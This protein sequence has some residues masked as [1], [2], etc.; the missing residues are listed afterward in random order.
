MMMIICVK[1]A[2]T[3]FL[4]GKNKNNKIQN[5]KYKYK[6]QNTNTNTNTTKK[7]KNNVHLRIL[8]FT[9]H[10]AD[11]DHAMYCHIHSYQV[12]ASDFD[13]FHNI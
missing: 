12:L 8:F 3:C 1:I 2:R 9:Y 4:N 13:I 6:I 7:T 11:L 10:R 5:T